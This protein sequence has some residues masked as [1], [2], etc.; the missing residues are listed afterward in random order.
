MVLIDGRHNINVYNYEGRH[1]SN[2]KY[3]GLRV[4]FLNKNSISVSSDVIGVIDTT[5]S[6][7]IKIFDVMN[8]QPLSINIVNSNEIVAMQLNQTEMKNERK[9]C[10][11]DSNRDMFL[12]MV[13]KPEI[14]KI[15][16]MVDSFS[17]NDNNDMLCALSDG[18]LNT[19]LY[20]NAIYVDKD[21]P[22]SYRMGT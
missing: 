19:W 12:T 6:K 7:M 13:N 9:L 5:N 16:S 15:S 14:I 17:W 21:V 1:I 2:P 8:G 4:E 20:P 18:K 10:F 3:Q 22:Y 11:I